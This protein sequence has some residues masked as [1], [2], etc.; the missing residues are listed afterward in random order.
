[1]FTCFCCFFKKA[2]YIP[3]LV[4]R[5]YERSKNYRFAVI[6]GEYVKG[7]FSGKDIMVKVELLIRIR[8]RTQESRI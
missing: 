8:S 4:T 5:S 2:F 6:D 7:K 1:M 3:R